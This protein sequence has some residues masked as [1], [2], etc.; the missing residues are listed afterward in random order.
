MI[1]GVGN[2]DFVVLPDM[3][4]DLWE[5]HWMLFDHKC[6][7]STPQIAEWTEIYKNFVRFQHHTCVSSFCQCF[8]FE[9]TVNF[10]G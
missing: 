4:E 10:G 5:M 9:M 6:N 2:V 8:D 7:Q 1:V 3:Y